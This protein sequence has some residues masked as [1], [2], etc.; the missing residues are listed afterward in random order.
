MQI[1]KI[2]LFLLLVILAV[3]F[4]L[5]NQWIVQQKVTLNY[6]LYSSSPLSLYTILLIDFFLGALLIACCSLIKHSK[7]KRILNQY[8][9][10]IDQMEKE[11]ISL[12]NLPITENAE[13]NVSLE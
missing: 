11:L 6:F 13:K 10:K 9:K 1:V 8:K 4:I 12:R 2:I 3:T 7:T 5:Q